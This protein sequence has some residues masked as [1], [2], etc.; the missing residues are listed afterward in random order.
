[1]E[2]PISVPG[3]GQDDAEVQGGMK[4]INQD[5][6][7]YWAANPG[8]WAALSSISR[9]VV[10]DEMYGPDEILGPDNAV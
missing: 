8:K 1:L 3:D 5:V 9:H 6:V 4:A 2:L 10:A 7:D